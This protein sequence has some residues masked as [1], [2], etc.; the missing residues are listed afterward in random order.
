MQ[1]A[2]VYGLMVR[3]AA[4]AA[5]HHEEQARESPLVLARAIA[6]K[7]GKGTPARKNKNVDAVGSHLYGGRIPIR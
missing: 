6:A 2:P 1:A 5:P 7:A 4:Y 3:D